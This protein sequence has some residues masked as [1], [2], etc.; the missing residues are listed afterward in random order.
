MSR[1][2]AACALGLTVG[3]WAAAALAAGIAVDDALARAEGI[4]KLPPGKRLVLYTDLEPRAEIDALP[5]LFDQAFPQWCRYFRVPPAEHPDWRLTGFL[6]KDAERCR[7]AGLLP[8]ELPPFRQGYSLGYDLWLYDQPSDYYRRHLL[9]HEGTH[10]FMRTILGGMG[11]PWYAEGMAELMATHRLAD[12]RLTLNIMPAD[13]EEVPQWGRIRLI[14]DAVAAKH[15]MRLAAILQYSGTAHLQVEPYAWCWAAA[16]L[17]DRHPRY[18]KRFRLLADDVLRPDFNDRF[19]QAFAPDWEQLNE[20]W[21]L[22]VVGIEYGYDVPLAAVDFTPGRPLPAGGVMVRVAAGRGW[23]N[24]MVRLEAGRGYRLAA[25][26]RYQVGSLPKG[27]WCEPGG[28]SIR[29]YQ[30]RPLGLLLA[31][32]RPEDTP[33]TGPFALLHPMVVGTGLTLRPEHAGTVYFKVNDSAARLRDNS[34]RLDVQISAA[35]N[36]SGTLRVPSAA[37]FSTSADGTRSV[38]ATSSGH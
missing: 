28:I 16:A 26:G 7:R 25:A 30:G 29:Y 27:L 18:Q 37:P 36:V 13:R 5:A 31:A 11:P 20:E 6:M 17:L 8:S 15:A 4:R 19:R 12:G 10:G 23:Q 22:F 21:S 9:L 38:P 33:A 24:S 3:L 1:Y 14:K 34:G 35:G 32:V 2:F